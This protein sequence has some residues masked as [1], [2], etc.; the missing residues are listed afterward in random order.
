MTYFISYLKILL[1]GNS[2]PAVV[3]RSHENNTSKKK[4]KLKI[5]E[6]DDWIN[7][8]ELNEDK[9]DIQIIINENLYTKSNFYLKNENYKLFFKNFYEI[10]YLR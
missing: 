1:F 6:I 9:N 7:K 5:E 4:V 3:Y 2:E 8:N 10:S